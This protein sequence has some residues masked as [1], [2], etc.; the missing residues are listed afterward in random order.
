MEPEKS[1]FFLLGAE[2]AI[3]HRWMRLA[4]LAT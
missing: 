2:R 1:I 4:E 3:T